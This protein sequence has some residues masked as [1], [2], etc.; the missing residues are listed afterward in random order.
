M[1]QLLQ[2]KHTTGQISKQIHFRVPFARLSKIYATCFFFCFCFFIN[3][4]KQGEENLPP[5][6][7]ILLK[8]KKTD[9][10]RDSMM[11]ISHTFFFLN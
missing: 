7:Q 1:L 6:E 10:C 2:H 9:S 11:K 3:I 5:T 4:Q 8:L